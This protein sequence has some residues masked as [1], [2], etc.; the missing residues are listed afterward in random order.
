MKCSAYFRK[1]KIPAAM[2]TNGTAENG[3]FTLVFS[4]FTNKWGLNVLNNTPFHFLAFPVAG[5]TSWIATLLSAAGLIKAIKSEDKEQYWTQIGLAALEFIVSFGKSL[6]I[7]AAVVVALAA[8]TL[9]SGLLVPIL[10]MG[11]MALSGIHQGIMAA[12][13]VLQAVKDFRSGN[14][15]GFKA[16]ALAALD[17]TVF[18]AASFAFCGIITGLMILAPHLG[19]PLIATISAAVGA[20]LT[21]GLIGYL[22]GRTIMDI[23][24][25]EIEEGTE[26]DDMS[27]TDNDNNETNLLL[28]KNNSNI[29]NDNGLDSTSSNSS[30]RAAIEWIKDSKAVS[31]ASAGAQCL[32]KALPSPSTIVDC[33]RDL[34]TAP[35]GYYL[36]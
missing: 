24:N 2:R 9:L 21:L 25:T 1:N 29:N 23:V 14:M 31:F 35:P 17:H 32:W 27:S 4:L 20:T 26:M 13:H 10:F 22:V 3:W 16:H 18:A 15:K 34:N 5:F 28:N 8:A 19:I 12:W 6:L 36:Q 7:T 33:C 11:A 30:F